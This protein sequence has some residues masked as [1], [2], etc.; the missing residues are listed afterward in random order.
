LWLEDPKR[1]DHPRVPA[2]SSPPSHQ[3]LRIAAASALPNTI[4]FQRVVDSDMNL[5]GGEKTSKMLVRRDSLEG[6]LPRT[7]RCA[8]RGEFGA[9][10][11]LLSDWPLPLGSTAL[12]VYA[13]CAG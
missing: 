8:T 6:Y 10:P 1:I 7:E 4:G 3:P 12:D 13:G 5:P 11:N 9:S 2:D